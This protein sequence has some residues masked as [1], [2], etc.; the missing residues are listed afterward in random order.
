MKI[1]DFKFKK[2]YKDAVIKEI[3]K[4]RKQGATFKEIAKY[5]N[6]AEYETFSGTG[7]WY[8]QSVHRLCK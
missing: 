8:T 5:L 3:K 2:Q 7:D 4:I 6:D 1:N